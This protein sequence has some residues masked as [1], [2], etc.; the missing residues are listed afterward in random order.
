MTLKQLSIAKSGLRILAG[1]YLVIG[2]L[3][4]A[5]LLLIIAEILGIVGVVDDDRKI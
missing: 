2:N 4:V 3:L 5:G 1:I